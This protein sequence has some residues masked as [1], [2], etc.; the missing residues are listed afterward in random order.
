MFCKPETIRA[1]RVGRVNEQEIA[2]NEQQ[3]QKV[4]G[5]LRVYTNI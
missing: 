2:E 4:S 3:Q 5:L 1:L